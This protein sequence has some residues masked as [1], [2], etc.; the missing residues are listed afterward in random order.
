MPADFGLLSSAAKVPLQVT[1]PPEVDPIKA[2][3]SMYKMEGQKIDTAEKVDAYKSSVKDRQVLQEAMQSGKYDITSPDGLDALTKDYGSQLSPDTS[4]RLVDR[5][6]KARDQH[7]LYQQHLASKS[8]G[9]VKQMHTNEEDTMGV[10]SQLLDH[11]DKVKESS[12]DEAAGKVFEEGRTHL[13][14]DLQ[15]EKMPDGSPRFPPPVI[16]KLSKMSPDDMRGYY[17]GSAYRKSLLKSNL[18]EKQI[19]L[20]EAKANAIVDPKEWDLYVTPSGDQYKFNK[21]AGGMSKALVDGQWV[22]VPAMPPDAVQQNNRSPKGAESPLGRLVADQEKLQKSGKMTTELQEKFNASLKKVAGDG[23]TSDIYGTMTA[24]EKSWLVEATASGLKI[25][26]VI[27]GSG[28]AAAI[29]NQEFVKEFVKTGIADGIPPSG[30]AMDQM[31]IKATQAALSNTLKQNA[32][33]SVAEESVK[34]SMGKIDEELKKIGGPDSPLLR[35]WWNKSMTEVLG[36]DEFAGLRP[37]MTEVQ[38]GMA[39]VYSGASGASGT[40]VGYLSLTKDTTDMNQNLGQWL[41]SSKS[42]RTLMD[43]RRLASKDIVGDLQR[44]TKTRITANPDALRGKPEAKD[45]DDGDHQAQDIK[46]N[47]VKAYNLKVSQLTN[48]QLRPDERKDLRAQ[49]RAAREALKKDGI[50]VPE[51]AAEVSDSGAKKDFSHLW[52]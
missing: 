2:Q 29:A 10:V 46:D 30:A 43:Q 18:E 22:D 27:P 49:V 3:S 25:P 26:R 17:A 7:V 47:K 6:Q 51:P 33:I 19:K 40:P 32:A 9:E 39:R 23:V 48:P 41:K 8:A 12:G 35:K 42:M 37:Y 44:G 21:K 13:L 38:E 15:A 45:P 20:D 24:E 14:T 1:P 34:Q 16:D 50:T 5:A 28:K 36:S 4:L 52:K 11:H 31:V